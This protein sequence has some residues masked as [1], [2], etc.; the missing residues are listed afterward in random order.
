M[1]LLSQLSPKMF[2]LQ[3]LHIQSSFHMQ[4]NLHIRSHLPVIV[5]Y[6]G[7]LTVLYRT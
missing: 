7:S 4:N 3:W 6:M 2:T 5:L 1:S